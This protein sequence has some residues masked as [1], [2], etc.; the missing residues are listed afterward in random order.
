MKII[1][2]I[3]ILMLVVLILALGTFVAGAIAKSYLAKQYLPPGQL[4]DVGGYKMH[5][6]CTGQGSPTVILDAG[7]G[8]FSVTWGL[9]QPEVAKTTRVCSYDRAGYGWSEPSPHP[10][11][12][13]GMA[14]ELHTLLAN[15]DIQGPYVLVGH[16]L[17]GLIVR[18]YTHSFPGE[19]AGMVLVDST[20]EEQYIR[21]STAVPK[22]IEVQRHGSAQVAKQYRL[23]GF[24]GSTGIMALVPQSI[25]NPGF[26]DA[27]FEQ[28]KAIWA[29]TDFFKTIL[30]EGEALEGILAE[31]RSMEITSFGNL[32][33][34]I[35]TAGSSGLD[36]NFSDTE[37]QQLNAVRKILQSELLG[38][39]SASKQIIAEQSSH[40]IQSDQPDLVIDAI[41][42]ILDD[43]R[44]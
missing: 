10:R 25:P 44:D 21:Q 5:I 35:L 36:P 40:Y 2:I 12:A 6:Y 26:S 9:V 18:I 43:L 34:I 28:Y 15:A 14:G 41:R 38:L 37:N 23:F 22:Y 20:H 4:V 39:S 13:S 29:T 7:L 11:T 32:P 33:L 1:R 16:S 3:S 27:E 42:E 31:A 24:L 17:G 30:G 8:D 19:V